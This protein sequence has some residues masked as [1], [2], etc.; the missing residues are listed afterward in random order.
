MESTYRGVSIRGWALYIV[1]SGMLFLYVTAWAALLLLGADTGLQVAL[2]V[3]GL[4]GTTIGT[5][6][7][8]YFGQKSAQ[9]PAPEPEPD[10]GDPTP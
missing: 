3:V 4:V 5:A 6:T 8:Y 9:A 7:G 1:I 2:M 10:P